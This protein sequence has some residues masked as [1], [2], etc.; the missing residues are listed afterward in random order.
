MRK[1][2]FKLRKWW[3]E[4][5]PAL[6]RFFQIIAS[7]FATLPLYYSTLPEE[8][9]TAIPSCYLKCVAIGGGITSFILQFFNKKQP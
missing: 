4:E 2:K 1:I 9:K 6:A 5:T 8:F 3:T 7:A